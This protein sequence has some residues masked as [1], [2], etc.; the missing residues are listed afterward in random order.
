MTT[1]RPVP[2]DFTMMLVIH[3]AFLRDLR[4]LTAALEG[5][6]DGTAS[7]GRAAALLERWEWITEQVHHHHRGEDDVLWPA[8]RRV[9]PDDPA[10]LQVLD[11]MEHEHDGLDP[12]QAELDRGLRAFA[13]A[14]DAATARAALG[15]ARAFT[16]ALAAHLA[17]EERAAVPLLEHR[18]PPAVLARF[19][20]GQQRQLG[21]RAAMTQFFPWL[22]DGAPPD[23]REHVLG[24]LPAPLRWWVLRSV[25]AH[26][27]R[28]APAWA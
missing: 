26:H 22:L 23:R 24:R 8:L 15:P 7:P 5:A 20:R 21:L 6:A 13:A 12:L 1:P 9:L 11:R 25:P 17:H 4:R 2:N 3:A 27:R 28:T 14:P 10:A 16:D 19:E 18:L